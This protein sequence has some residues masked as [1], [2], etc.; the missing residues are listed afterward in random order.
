MQT[1]C[2]LTSQYIRNFYCFLQNSER[3]PFPLGGIAPYFPCND[4]TRFPVALIFF[5]FFLIFYV[6]K[7]T[8]KLHVKMAM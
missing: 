8:R 2:N 4:P 3:K 1:C 5:N 6:N 7:I